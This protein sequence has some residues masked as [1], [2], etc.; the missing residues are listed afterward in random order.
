MTVRKG[1][2]PT[3]FLVLFLDLVGF[4]IVF[5]L[6]AELLNFYLLQDSGLLG[7]LLRLVDA[8][9]PADAGH[10]Q[11]A[12]LFGGVLAGG[13]AGLQFLAAPFWGRLSD[14]IGRRPVLLVSLTGSL[15]A[16]VLWIVSFHFELLLIARLLAGITSGNVATA[17][18]A[19]ADTTTP[20]QRGR[21][22]GFVGMAF[23]LGFILGP[24]IGGLS[25][26]L[27]P[28]PDAMGPLLHPFSAV[29][30]VATVLAAL[31]LVIAWRS[32]PETHPPERRGKAGEGRPVNPLRI[33][34]R[35]LGAGVA[36]INGAFLLHT[37]LFSGMEA[38]L[39]FLVAQ[40]LGFGIG[41]TTALFVAMGLMAA[42]MQGGVYRPLVN[43][44]GPR[45][46]A[47][48][49]LLALIPGFALVALVAWHPH[50]WLLWAG[51]LVMS[52]GTG[53]AFPAMGTIASLAADPARQG[54]AMGAYR[55]AGA[56]G[57]ALGPL[58]AAIAYF[59]GGPEWPYLIGAIGMVLP[60]VLVLGVRR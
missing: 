28:R 27:L 21:A 39:V 55:S 33:F 56:L 34:D 15:L 14:R 16:N 1:V 10:W 26:H 45:A 9:A 44:V 35:S 23:G 51:V 6:Y 48:C 40:Q 29:A 5:P 20:E 4:G 58:L 43:R 30:V 13:Y 60:L 22:M 25:Y 19:I 7:M 50:A 32:F 12:A 3:V 54:W 52:V 41:A 24:A 11:R 31:N 42:A 59:H 47:L 38:T 2:L 53:L 18:A 57:R 8:V 37:L 36:R 49:G 46:L 17:N